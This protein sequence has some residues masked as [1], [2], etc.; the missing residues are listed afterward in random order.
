M[1]EFTTDD[2]FIDEF[3]IDCD[4]LVDADKGRIKND[5]LLHALLDYIDYDRDFTIRYRT[6]TINNV[7]ED[8]CYNSKTS[9]DININKIR[10]V[11][12][13]DCGVLVFLM[14]DLTIYE[15]DF[16]TREGVDSTYVVETS[17]DDKI[18]EMVRYDMELYMEREYFRSLR[19]QEEQE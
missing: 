13:E 11:Y 12:Y 14:K 1:I 6:L 4:C 5:D 7:I 16:Y 15:F 8:F 9:F 17:I 10:R 18:E 19:E 3:Y 2:E